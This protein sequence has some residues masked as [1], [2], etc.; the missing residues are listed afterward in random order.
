MLSSLSGKGYVSAYYQLNNSYKLETGS[1]N[2]TKVYSY[3]SK[4]ISQALPCTTFSAVANLAIPQTVTLYYTSGTGKQPLAM[5]VPAMYRNYSLPLNL[6]GNLSS[7]IRVSIF[8]LFTA[9]A[10]SA[11]I[12]NM[13]IGAS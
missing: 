9:N 8:A 11:S 1:F 6:T 10:T 5:L 7:K 13:S 4:N 2:A 3:I 12:Y